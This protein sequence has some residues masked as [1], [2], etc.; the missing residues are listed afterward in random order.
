MCGVYF[1]QY[2]QPVGLFGL[3]LVVITTTQL[4]IDKMTKYHGNKGTTVDQSRCYYQVVN[5][6]L[7]DSPPQMSQ[8]REVR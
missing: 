1:V 3:F 5:D 2:I 8:E 4:K 7:A 6:R